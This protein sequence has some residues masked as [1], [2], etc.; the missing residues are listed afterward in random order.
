MLLYRG[1]KLRYYS[2][3]GDRGVGAEPGHRIAHRHRGL[4][5]AAGVQPGHKNSRITRL[6]DPR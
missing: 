5:H 1:S 6:G 4:F 3:V 2:D